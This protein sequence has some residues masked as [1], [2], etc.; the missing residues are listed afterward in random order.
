M[1]DHTFTDIK[2]KEEYLK[3]DQFLR[4]N[5]Q[6]KT[7]KELTRETEEACDIITLDPTDP[8]DAA[9]ISIVEIN[10]RKRADYAK[11]DDPFSNFE[12]TAFMLGIDEFGPVES[13]LFN[14]LQKIAR[15]QS[16]RINGRMADTSNESVMDTYLDLAVY[17]IITYALALK[18]AKG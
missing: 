7:L 2:A 12:T 16:L 15:L 3:A 1:V 13:A 4:D 6:H 5:P 17:G 9:L 18:Q 10:R 11:D 8:F 14:M